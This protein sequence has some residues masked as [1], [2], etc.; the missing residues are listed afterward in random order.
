MHSVLGAKSA[1]SR[2]PAPA[3]SMA[4]EEDVAGLRRSLLKQLVGED[5][6]KQSDGLDVYV[7]DYSRP[8]LLS[9]EGLRALEHA[10]QWLAEEEGG[11]AQQDGKDSDAASAS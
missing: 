6:F 1:R 7:E 4:E 9:R 2:V 8:E 5:H 10:R 11:S 3:A